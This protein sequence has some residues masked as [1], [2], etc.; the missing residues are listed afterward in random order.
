MHAVFHYIPLHLSPM[1]QRFDA[2][3]GPLPVTESVADRL[4]RLPC[5]FELGAPDQ[6]RVIA[7]VRGFYGT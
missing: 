3:S 1:G 4:V 2:G 5:Y 6:D 7:A